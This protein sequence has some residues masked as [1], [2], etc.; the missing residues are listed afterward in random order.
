MDKVSVKTHLG[1]AKFALAWKLW[2]LARGV[3]ALFFTRAHETT[4]GFVLVRTFSFSTALVGLEIEAAGGAGHRPR[5]VV[6]GVY[7]TQ[8]CTAKRRHFR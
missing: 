8:F 7:V 6:L 4:H 3:V 1:H 5:A 2:S